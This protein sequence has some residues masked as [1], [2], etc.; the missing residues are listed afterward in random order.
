MNIEANNPFSLTDPE[1][2]A[3]EGDDFVWKRLQAARGQGFR[4]AI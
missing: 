4:F 2:L 3:A 1:P